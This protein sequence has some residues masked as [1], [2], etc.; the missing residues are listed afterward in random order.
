M[1]F[2]AQARKAAA[3][4]GASRKRRHAQAVEE[5]ACG[6]EAGPAAPAAK[7]A[8]APDPAPAAPRQVQGLFC[9]RIRQVGLKSQTEGLTSNMNSRETMDS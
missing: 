3:S 5:D 7:D 1:C 6:N 8:A 2:G 9:P 4:A